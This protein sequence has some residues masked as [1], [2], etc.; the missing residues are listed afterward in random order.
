MT[1]PTARERMA[2]AACEAAFHWHLDREN[3]SWRDLWYRVADA[4]TAAALAQ[5]RE[6]VLGPIEALAEELDSFGSERDRGNETDDA[7][8]A[9]SAAAYL[10]AAYLIRRTIAGTR[11]A[12]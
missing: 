9:A 12:A 7:A 5:A 8:T 1:E 6:E 11:D 2:D 3:D 10:R 4:I